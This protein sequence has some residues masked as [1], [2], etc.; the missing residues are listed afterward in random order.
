M[1]VLLFLVDREAGRV[2]SFKRSA[3]TRKR[4]TRLEKRRSRWAID[5]TAESEDACGAGSELEP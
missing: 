5:S 3:Y 2:Q 4:E 1:D